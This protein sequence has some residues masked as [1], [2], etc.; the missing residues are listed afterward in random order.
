MEQALEEGLECG[1]ERCLINPPYHAPLGVI[2]RRG[3]RLMP[4]RP[5]SGDKKPG[6]SV[7]QR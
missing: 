5:L 7:N 3:R 2:L 4:E 1:R 6:S